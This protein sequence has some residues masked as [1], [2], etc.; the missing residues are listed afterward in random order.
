MKKFLL[1]TLAVSILIIS[2]AAGQK[3]GLLN[4]VAKSVSNATNNVVDKPAKSDQVKIQPEPLCASDEATVAMDLGGNLQLDYKEL[5]ISLLS[6]GRILAQAHGANEYYVAKD[7]TT[8]G[9]FKAGDPQIA[10]FVAKDESKEKNDNPVILFKP[11]VSKTGD[12]YTI[13]FAGKKYGPYA[14]I[15]N[16]VVTPS[17]DKFAA[18]VTENVVMTEDQGKKMEQAM[19]NAKDDQERMELA[20]QY[21]QLMQENMGSGGAETVKSKLIS[22]VPNATYDAMNMPNATLNSEIK[23]DDIVV[24]TY[25]NKIYDLQGKLLFSL[26]QGPGEVQKMFINSGS[27]KYATYGYGTLSFSDNTK[28]T[29]LF[30][31]SL[32][33]ADGKVWMS[34]MYY[35]PKHNAIMRHKIAF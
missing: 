14:I 3:S 4:K 32:I 17:K 30:N 22:N 11:Y 21:A 27:T 35:S 26:K 13:T 7:G 20:M 9:P 28:L 10:D 19:K 18:M 29:D 25:T 34:Y 1:I 5:T 15:S 6:D 24:T 33:K 23:Y 8:T 2:P 31:P 16:L 12:K